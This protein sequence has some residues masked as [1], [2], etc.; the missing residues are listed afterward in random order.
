M[1]DLNHLVVSSCKRLDTLLPSIYYFQTS[2]SVG[3]FHISRTVHLISFS[4]E[5]LKVLLSVVSNLEQFDT[6]NI[7]ELWQNRRPALCSSSFW[8]SSTKV[9]LSI[10]TTTG[11]GQRTLIL[12]FRFC[13]WSRTSLNFKSTGERLFEQQQQVFTPASVDWVLQQLFIS[14]DSITAGHFYSFREIIT[15]QIDRFRS[16]TALILIHFNKTIYTF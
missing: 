11:S 13:S 2:L 1:N 3:V 4:C 14:C 12:Q 9:T 6:F 10:M 16:D 5:L 7:N 15:G 8:D